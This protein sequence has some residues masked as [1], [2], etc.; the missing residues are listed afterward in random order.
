MLPDNAMISR[1]CLRVYLFFEANSASGFAMRL[2]SSLASLIVSTSRS[3]RRSSSTPR[4][5]ISIRKSVAVPIRTREKKSSHSSSF[6]GPVLGADS[7][8]AGCQPL[9]SRDLGG[10]PSSSGSSTTIASTGGSFSFPIHGMSSGVMGPDWSR[11]P[12][13]MS[14]ASPLVPAAARGL[15]GGILVTPVRWWR[16]CVD[17]DGYRLG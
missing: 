1:P 15:R 11:S 4:N 5:D 7:I 6:G 3:D 17:R 2:R 8:A 12:I 16:G 13:V 10:V 9:F 14:T